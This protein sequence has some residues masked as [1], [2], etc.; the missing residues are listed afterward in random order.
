VETFINNQRGKILVDQITTTDKVKRIGKFV[1]QL[2]EK[3]MLRVER[4]ICYVLA[5]STEALAE[6][7][8]E[9]QKKII[10]GVGKSTLSQALATEASKQKLK[11]LLADYD[12]Q[13]KII[14]INNIKHYEILSEKLKKY[15]EEEWHHKINPDNYGGISPL[16]EEMLKQHFVEGTDYSVEINNSGFKEIKIHSERL[17][18]ARQNWWDKKR[19]PRNY[20]DEIADALLRMVTN[21]KQQPP[22]T[23]AELKALNDP[24]LGADRKGN[25][26]MGFTGG[27]SELSHFDNPQSDDYKAIQALKNAGIS[28]DKLFER[29]KKGRQVRK[30]KE[31]E[32]PEKDKN[33]ILAN[34]EGGDGKDFSKYE[35]VKLTPETYQETINKHEKLRIKD[36]NPKKETGNHQQSLNNSDHRRDLIIIISLVVNT[37]FLNENIPFSQVLLVI[38]KEE[39]E[40]IDRQEALKRAR[41]LGLDLFC[42]APDKNPPVCKLINYQKYAFELSKKK[43]DKKENICKEV[44]ISFNIGEKDLKDKLERVNKWTE[45]G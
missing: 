41:E 4:A 31:Q 25:D 44:R 15:L 9:R 20:S 22:L 11:T 32:K 36:L 24:I 3:L 17:K 16:S 8:K 30:I 21:G 19:G 33:K 28:L 43:K 6:E 26:F 10:G 14:Y 5:I 45:K 37:Q 34:I 27:L 38:D 39:K 23:E 7:L 2:D 12:P 35:K 13:Q 29:V 40:I 18:K 42:V 1:G